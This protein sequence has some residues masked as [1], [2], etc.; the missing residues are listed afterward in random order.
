VYLAISILSLIFALSIVLL[1]VCMVCAALKFEQE[2]WG[3]ARRGSYSVKAEWERRTPV[4][5]TAPR[6]W[7]PSK[8]QVEVLVCRRCGRWNS[9]AE[10]NCWSCQEVLPPSSEAQIVTFEAAPHCA[11]CGYWVYPREQVTLCPACRAQGHRAHMMEY[12]KAKGTCPAC[13]QRLSFTQLLH[14]TPVTEVTAN[15][16]DRPI[17]ELLMDKNPR[18]QE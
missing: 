15:S 16:T 18:P 12:V 7:R 8:H 14:A 4:K 2:R 11:V 17:S 13:G 1:I 6:G 3:F 5:G 9:P 10:G